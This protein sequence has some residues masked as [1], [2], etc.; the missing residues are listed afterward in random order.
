[1]KQ[2][3]DQS[4]YLMM[5]NFKAYDMNTKAYVSNPV[6]A[7]EMDWSKFKIDPIKTQTCTG[8]AVKPVPTFSVLGQKGITLKDLRA[9]SKGIDIKVAYANNVKAGTA[10]VTVTGTE[11]SEIPVSFAQVCAAEHRNLQVWK[12]AR[13][14]L[15]SG[16]VPHLHRRHWRSAR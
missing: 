1:M 10:K 8:K 11:R 15:P 12:G 5:Y 3:S 4:M 9:V 7:L 13:S 2:A 6:Y 16:C 14:D